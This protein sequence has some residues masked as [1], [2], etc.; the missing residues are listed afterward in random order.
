VPLIIWLQGGPGAPSQFGCF[1]EVGPIF[2]DG[3]KG[4]LKATEN[5]WG[6]NFF[7]HLMCVDQPVG[8]GFSYNNNTKKVDNSKDAANHFANFLVNFYKNNPAFGL[9]GNPVY[10]AG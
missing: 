4:N 5:P 1:N 8:V 10:L 7:G 9:A 6:W 3:K 2:I